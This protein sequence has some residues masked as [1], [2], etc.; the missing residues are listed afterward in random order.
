MR[1]HSVAQDYP[2]SKKDSQYGGETALQAAWRSNARQHAHPQAQIAGRHVHKQPFENVAVAA[3]MK[4]WTSTIE[5]CCSVLRRRS[6]TSP[7]VTVAILGF[8]RC[9]IMNGLTSSGLLHLDLG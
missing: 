7:L 6:F 2:Q 9:W 4:T 3:Q 5:R 1:G 8:S